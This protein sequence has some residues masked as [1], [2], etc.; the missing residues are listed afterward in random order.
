V[1]KDRE[2]RLEPRTLA[3]PDGH[4]TQAN[5]HLMGVARQAPAPITGRSVLQLEAEGQKEGEDALAKRLAIVQQLKVRGF[6]SEIDG[7]GPVFTGLV[8]CVSH[9]HPQ[10]RWSL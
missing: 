5:P 2:H 8:G 4:P 3:T 9:G 1:G 7:D 6:V 10:V